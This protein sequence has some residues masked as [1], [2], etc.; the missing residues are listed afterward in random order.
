MIAESIRR[1][2]DE[3]I[4]Y[5]GA[6]TYARALTDAG[7]R[8]LKVQRDMAQGSPLVAVYTAPPYDLNVPSLPAARLA[9]N[10]TRSRVSGGIEGDRPRSFDARRHSL[11]LTPP[12][13]PVA[14]EKESPS[15]HMQIYFHP[16][17]LKGADDEPSRHA[18]V[19]ALFN[20]VVPGLNR[21]V[22]ELVGELLAPGY[23]AD[24][25]A[26]S[27]GRLVVVCVARHLNRAARHLPAL[28]PVAFAR[29]RE[30]LA[31]NLAERLLVADLARE[32]GLS[33]D[34]FAYEFTRLAGQP[35]HRYL[36]SMR[37]E[38]ALKL[39]DTTSLSLAEIA[40]ACGFASQQHMS[41]A[42]VRRLGTTPKR[43]RMRSRG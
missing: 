38:R 12:A 3:R 42:I 30:Y 28:T 10:L 18:G 13:V 9:V 5:A 23:L 29:L 7:G 20:V 35:P 1:P 22:D 25:V 6:R 33:P 40:H 8:E 34:R 24:E 39:L 37:I 14:W 4:E 27:L 26:D 11:F 19:P 41:N 16:D 36:R 43:Y 32:V 21:L 15:R 17:M 31:A 2:D